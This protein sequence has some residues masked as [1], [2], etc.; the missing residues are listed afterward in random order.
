MKK[1]LLLTLLSFFSIKSYS[2]KWI[3]LGQNDIGDKTYIQNEKINSND[4]YP[5][6][7]SKEYV[8]LFVTQKN[9]V[10]IPVKNA[11]VKSL[12]TYDCSEK[13]KKY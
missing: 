2:Q 10:K 1:Y 9:G 6:V 11:I 7:W 5:K 12:Y 3:Y 4:D 8:S 13:R